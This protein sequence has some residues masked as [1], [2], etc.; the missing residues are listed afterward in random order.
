MLA[1]DVDSLVHAEPLTGVRLLPFDDPLTKLDQEL[2]VPD[3][4]L[5]AKVFPAVGESTG[6]IPGA[7][8]VDGAVAGAWQRQGRR[9]TIHPWSAPTAGCAQRSNGRHWRSRSPRHRRR[10][11]AGTDASIAS[12]TP[13]AAGRYPHSHGGRGPR[14]GARSGGGA[15][16]RHRGCRDPAH[17]GTERTLHPHRHRL[18]DR[19]DDDR[20]RRLLPR[21]RRHRRGTAGLSTRAGS[22]WSRSTRRTTRCPSRRTAE[23]WVKRTPPDF[24][25]DIKA[26]ALMTGQPTETKRLPK[27][28]R[29]GA[30][31]GDRRE[32][33]GLRQGPARRAAGRSS[34][35]GSW[36]DSSR[37]A[38][39]ASWAPSCSSTRAG[40]SPRPRTA[41]PSRSP[42]G[43]SRGGRGQRRRV[44]Q[45]ILVQREE[46]RADAA[47]PGGA[48][49]S[50]WSW[51]TN[52]RA[53]SRAC[54]RSWRRRRR[55]WRSCASTGAVPRPGR[56]AAFPR[57]SASATC[58]TATS[59]RSG[60]R[61]SARRR[62]DARET[63]VLFNNCYS[64]YGATN[65]VEL[66]KLLRDLGTQ[67]D[68][69]AL[70][71]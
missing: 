41:P 17:P 25:F 68:E 70:I 57:S 18:V 37:C 51:W 48:R 55:T 50:R 24:T 52:R 16:R 47:L 5:R 34:G 58:T 3:G 71:R 46:P 61:A 4:A 21:R 60:C 59:W 42:S 26:H 44:P 28:I 54:R 62:R 27:D 49:R 15:R 36:T 67:R 53:S 31:G 64:N 63:H 30:A 69:G 13:V 23:L 14:P 11:Y 38:R 56:S 39:R 65:A 40:S 43:G 33:A 8:L 7:I 12:T 10:A 2:L 6:Y 20:T 22:R 32:G 29:D 9:V 1:E 19:S 66:A 35:S 45:C